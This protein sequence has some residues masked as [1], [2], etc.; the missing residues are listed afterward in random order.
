MNA[1]HLMQGISAKTPRLLS[2]PW[3]N[4][5]PR[6]MACSTTECN[7]L[8]RFW[9]NRP[10]TR[11]LAVLFEH[12]LCQVNDT[13]GRAMMRRSTTATLLSFVIPGTGLWYLGRHRR[14]VVNF[15]AAVLASIAGLLWANEYVHYVIL[16]IAAGSAGYAH[17]TARTL[18]PSHSSHN[19]RH[20]HEAQN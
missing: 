11:I 16:G 1:L 13:H 7:L 18:G 19:A 5:L 4:T 17:A 12:N 3:T 20:G 15:V 14:A 6:D 10:G 8:Q 2:L 9:R